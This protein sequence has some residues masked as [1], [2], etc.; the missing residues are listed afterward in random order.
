MNFTKLLICGLAVTTSS[1]TWAMDEEP[2]PY[3]PNSSNPMN[4]LNHP[5]SPTITLVS[6]DD[7]MTTAYAPLK[8]A[9]RSGGTISV[10]LTGIREV[11]QSS[12]SSFESFKCPNSHITYYKLEDNR[13]YADV[14]TVIAY[15]N[16]TGEFVLL[17]KPENYKADQNVQS[18]GKEEISEF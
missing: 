4:T 13:R 7:P 3:T 11:P 2:L 15:K 10:D 1:L 8:M 9:Q 17:K 18:Y 16:V 6:L 14:N 12:L 5:F